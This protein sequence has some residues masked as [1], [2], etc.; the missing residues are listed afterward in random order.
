MNRTKHSVLVCNDTAP[1]TFESFTLQLNS[2]KGLVRKEKMEG[3]DYTVVPMVM[4]KEG[5]L[6]GS[7]GPLFYPADEWAASV[8]IW[9]H[10]P[11]VVYH[12]T[13][14]GKGVSACDPL[15]LTK[16][17]IGVILNTRFQES[18]KTL[19][20]E[21]WLEDARIGAVD[22]RVGKAV[23]NEQ[24]MEL[25][26]GVFTQNEMTTGEHNGRKYSAIARNLR[27]DH[28]AVL[29]DKIGACSVKDGAGF[30]RNS[31]GEEY[32][33]VDLRLNAAADVSFDQMRDYLWQALRAKFPAPMGI[34][35]GYCFP[36]IVAMY[37]DHVVYE[38]GGKLYRTSYT[39]GTG[40]A[41]LTGSATEV[42]RVVSYAPVSNATVENDT[43]RVNRI[44]R[45]ALHSVSVD[46]IVKAT[47]NQ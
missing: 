45:N 24:M 37:D 14:N 16:H 21:A 5:V 41:N 39:L 38:M 42:T 33:A 30:I 25:S 23:E 35:T 15:L 31:V 32:E 10:K 34:D 3:R 44:A 1:G 46:R 18:D 12:P 28:L 11:V 43:D 17:K 2:K 7:Q 40:K 6:N 9:N 47:L 13:L 19:R 26:T 8:P 22:R 4:A 36:Y 27:G 29:P 20:A